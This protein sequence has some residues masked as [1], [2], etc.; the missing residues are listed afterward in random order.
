MAALNNMLRYM[1]VNQDV[2]LGWTYW[3]G[4]PWWG[5]GRRKLDPVDEQDVPQMNLLERH[6]PEWTDDA[7]EQ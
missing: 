1:Q 5:P 3:A 4:G 7:A 6:I 2:W